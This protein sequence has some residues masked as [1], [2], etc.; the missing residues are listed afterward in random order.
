MAE[1]EKQTNVPVLEPVLRDLAK[2][3]SKAIPRFEEKEA[4]IGVK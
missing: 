1:A 2:D 3:A 4:I